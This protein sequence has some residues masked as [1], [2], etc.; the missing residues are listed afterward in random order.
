MRSSGGR[1]PK[2]SRIADLLERVLADVYGEGGLVAEG[3]LPAA[4][5]TGTIDYVA[6]MHGVR[7]PAAAGSGFTPLI[8]AEGRMDLGGFLAT[9]RR[10]P[11]AAATR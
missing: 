11:P 5:V 9:E 3:A 10:R 2:A 7:P 8:S 4:A 6:A 1:S